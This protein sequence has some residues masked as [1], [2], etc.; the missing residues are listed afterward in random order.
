MG[1]IPPS[2]HKQQLSINIRATIC[3][4]RLSTSKQANRVE[5]QSFLGKQYA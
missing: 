4:D 5:L 1:L 3:G 2:H